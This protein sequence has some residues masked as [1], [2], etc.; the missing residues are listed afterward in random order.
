M[1]IQLRLPDKMLAPMHP[2]HPYEV[3][4]ILA[5]PVVLGSQDYL[6]W[7]D[8]ELAQAVDSGQ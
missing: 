1:Q 5:F 7:M 8:H 4:E 6:E 2:F 3:P